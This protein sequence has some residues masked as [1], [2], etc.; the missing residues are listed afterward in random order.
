MS[1]K[2][3]V[4]WD[5][6]VRDAA[7]S[8]LLA[9]D[10]NQAYSNLLLNETIKRHK[11]EAKDRALLTELTYGTLQHK[12]TLDYY[13]EPFIRGSIDHWVRWLLRISLYQ[14]QYLTRIPAHAAVNEAVEIAKRRGHRGIAS[15]VNGILRS[16]LRQGVP[17][18]TDIENPI[19]R[20]AIET[21]HPI[22]LVQRFVD[23]YGLEV[24]TG[25][26]HENNVPPMQTVRVNTTKVTVEQAIAELEAEGLSAK[27]SDVIPECL[28]LTNGQ[29]ARTHA[30]KEGH[31]TIQDESSMIP[32]NVLNPS[33]GMRV[34]DMCA[35]P[36]GKTTH[37]AE[38]MKNEGSILAT[39]LHPHK[40]DLIDHNTERL[41]LDIIETAPI[42]GRKAPEF[43][44]AES[45]DAVLVDAPCSGLGV[46]R[47]KPDIKYTKREEDLENLQTIQLALLDA[48][49]KVLKIEGKLVYSTCT[50][51]IQENEGTVKAFLATHPEMEAI[52]L[53]SLPTKLAEKQAN[54]MLQVFPQDF[55]SDGFFVAAFRKKGESN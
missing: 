22:W 12:M 15:T 44:Q 2:S 25:M 6:N 26:L 7:L 28:H 36:G 52:Q 4:I 35:A 29:P 54:G 17:A 45:Y 43:L 55:G 8:I 37:L 18:I 32:A 27:Q 48:A 49:T 38:I 24:A 31:I 42:D 16:V 47:R 9:V 39:D 10:K 14:M 3:V 34:L 23:N 5:G 51:D 13:L 19:E 41:G 46:M 53:E 30:F 21:S 33:P 50:V 11:I 20:L 40:L 1:K